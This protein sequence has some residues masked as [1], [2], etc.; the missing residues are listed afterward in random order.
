M[1]FRNADYVYV[2]AKCKSLIS[3]PLLDGNSF[4]HILIYQA[5]DFSGFFLVS[6]FSQNTLSLQTHSLNDKCTA[7]IYSTTHGTYGFTH[8]HVYIPSK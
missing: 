4:D 5:C 7:F 3:K 6:G 8:V 2:Y 1:D